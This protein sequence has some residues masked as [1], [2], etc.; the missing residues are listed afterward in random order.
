M[1]I[2]LGVDLAGEGVDSKGGTMP[3][4]MYHHKK[5]EGLTIEAVAEDHKRT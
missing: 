5:L 1:E 3:L 4:N 2:V